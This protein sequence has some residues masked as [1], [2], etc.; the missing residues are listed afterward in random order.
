MNKVFLIGRLTKDPELKFTTGSGAAVATFSIAVDRTF[1]KQDGQKEADFLNIVCWNKLAELVANNLGKGRLVAVSGQIR[2]R[3]YQAQDG[4]K[5]YV[6]EII[7]DEV[8]FLDRPK[9][10]GQGNYRAGESRG[11]FAPS[12]ENEFLPVD[13]ED[14]PF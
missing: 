7:A 5:V 4:R 12:N 3:N 6:T 9:D 14:I 1:T 8:K 13:D 10:G 2:T 11:E